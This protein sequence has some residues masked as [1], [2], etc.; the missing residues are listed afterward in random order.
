MLPSHEKRTI[1]GVLLDEKID[2]LTR[3]GTEKIINRAKLIHSAQQA[4]CD[5]VPPWELQEEEQQV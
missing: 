4:I 2:L 3:K 5:S 1:L